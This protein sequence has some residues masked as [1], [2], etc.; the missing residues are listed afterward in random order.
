M[1]GTDRSL[2]VLEKVL[3]LTSADQAEV[4]LQR[5]NLNMTRFANS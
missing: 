5:E 4:R 3:K 1:I 2:E